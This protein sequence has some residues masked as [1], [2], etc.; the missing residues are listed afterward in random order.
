MAEENTT[1]LLG[2]DDAMESGIKDSDGT[3]SV[4]PSRSSSTGRAP[5]KYH[6]VLSGKAF[7]DSSNLSEGQRE[8]NRV[9]RET[10]SLYREV[11]EGPVGGAHKERD[12]EEPYESLAINLSN[13]ANVVLL[14]LKIFAS[15]KSRSL[16]IVAS[17][18]ESLLDLL[19]GVILLFTRWSMRRENVYK[20]PI[21][22]LRTQPVGIVIFAAI[23]ATLGVQ[24]LITAVEHL[25]EGDDGNKMNSSELVWM[26]VVM[27]VA[28]AAKLALYLFCRTFKSEIVHAY[29][30]DH[31]FDA[32]TNIV[33][34]AAALL[35][36][37]Y[38]WWIDPIGALVLAVYTIVEWSKAVLENA[39]SLIGKAAPPELI[40]KLTL[41]TISHH[42]A[43]RR[44]DTVRAYTFGSLYF[45][46]VD[47]ELPEQ[48][49]LREAHD[50]GE[51]LQN[52]IEDLPEVERA[53]VH[54]DFE[55]RHRPEHTRQRGKATGLMDS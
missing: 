20:Y 53:Y 5:F 35:A 41:I 52:K 2:G 19:A 8:Y 32:L 7:N 9:Q 43:I 6:R 30:L 42:E 12:E 23:M 24:V 4:Q 1:P 13:I 38:Y 37:R 54:L 51:D 44:I 18:L 15:V 28:T 22:K 36:N 21:G 17:T 48:M 10:L 50:I 49:H 27:V 55:S 3:A 16:A 11:A 26:T 40:R 39:G 45:V 47:I 25:L 29:S 31:G 46:E 33:G 34:L 14:V